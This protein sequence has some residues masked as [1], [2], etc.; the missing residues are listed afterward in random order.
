MDTSSLLRIQN[1]HAGYGD[2]P[3]LWDI[4]LKVDRRK[5]IGLLG[6]NGA[7]K[8][9]LL[10]VISG[11]ISPMKGRVHFLEEDI[12]FSNPT[13]R[14]Q[15]GI[16][17]IPEGRLLFYGLTVKQN[18]RL[19]AFTRKDKASLEKGLDA[20]FQLFPRLAERK[21]QLAGTLSG[22]EQ[23]MCAIGRGL[24]S[25]PKLLLID[26]LSWGLAP[27]VVDHIMVALKKVYEEMELSMILVEQDVQLG[28]E[29]SH[30][31]YVLETGRIVKEGR[32]EDIIKDPDI[33]KSYL[34]I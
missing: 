13:R 6:G 20:I 16:T 14:V 11:I 25:R 4:F 10:N 5:I 33:R 34:G 30:R 24:M 19:G 32:S 21:D 28:L 3:V 31:A 17:Q 27:L 22:G 2:V 29:F 15:M 9:T 8:T 18:L 7:G 1:L 23:Q 12:T 26:E